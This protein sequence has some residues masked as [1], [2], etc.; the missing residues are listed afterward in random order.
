MFHHSIWILTIWHWDCF[1][2]YSFNFKAKRQGKTAEENLVLP[3]QDTK[4]K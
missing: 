3:N 4:E 1:R 2:L